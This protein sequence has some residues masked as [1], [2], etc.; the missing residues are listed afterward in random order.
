MLKWAFRLAAFVAMAAY[1]ACVSV[2]AGSHWFALFIVPST[3]N[4]LGRRDMWASEEQFYVACAFVGAAAALWFAAG[5]VNGHFGFRRLPQ[6]WAGTRRVA[7][8]GATYGAAAGALLMTLVSGRMFLAV[9]MEPLVD[10]S[11]WRTW[12]LAAAALEVV[13]GI[14][15]GALGGSV[16]ALVLAHRDPVPPFQARPI[17]AIHSAPWHRRPGK[18]SILA[19][20]VVAVLIFL[21]KATSPAA[22]ATLVLLSCSLVYFTV[23]ALFVRR[24]TSILSL[25]PARSFSSLD[26]WGAIGGAMCGAAI[27]LRASLVYVARSPSIEDAGQA[28]IGGAAAGAIIGQAMARSAA[29]RG[30]PTSA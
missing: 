26:G 22:A 4:F 3:R 1:G 21:P 23:L 11:L 9:S 29:F 14:L 24:L 12:P 8:I 30:K 16:L 2:F 6:G 13:P 10:R 5:A 28:V 15:I 20:A 27:G 19:L 18:I 17:S 7:S 25:G